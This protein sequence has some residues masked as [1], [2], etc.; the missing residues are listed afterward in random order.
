MP[1][2]DEGYTGLAR[3][4]EASEIQ[5]IIESRRRASTGRGQAAAATFAAMMNG[6]VEAVKAAL[7]QLGMLRSPQSRRTSRLT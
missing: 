6:D 2:F 7:I 3:P 5:A 4:A 1:G